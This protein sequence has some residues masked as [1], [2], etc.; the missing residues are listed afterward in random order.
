MLTQMVNLIAHR[1]PDGINTWHEGS[2]GL[3][4]CMLWTTPE[5]VH[6][7]LPLVNSTGEK[8]ITADARIDNRDDLLNTFAINI[9]DATEISDSEII[10]MSYERWGTTCV[11][12]LLGDFAFAIW[13]KRHQQMFCAR[14]HMGIKSFYY[15]LSAEMF[16]FAT[17]IKVLLGM[18]Q[19]PKIINE[20]RVADYLSQVYADNTSTLYQQIYRLPPAHF[21]T[22]GL[23]GENLNRYWSL[24]LVDD[25]QLKSDKEYA[26]R[27]YEIFEKAVRCRLRSS[28]RIGFALSGGLDSSSITCSARNLINDNVVQSLNT[29]SAIF[30]TLDKECRSKVD[31]TEY[32]QTI[33][34]MGGFDPHFIHADKISPL[35]DLEKIISFTDEVYFAPNLF[36]F[37]EL[38]NT[39][40]NEGIRV[41]LDGVDGDLTVS[42]GLE[43]LTDLFR[44]GRW[45]KL[46]DEAVEISRKSYISGKPGKII[47]HY[48]ILPQIPDSI[49]NLRRRFQQKEPPVWHLVNPELVQ[50]LH[51]QDRI[52]NIGRSNA[53]HKRTAKEFHKSDLNTSQLMLDLEVIDKIAAAA[54]L[55]VR[56]PFFD[57]RL[58]EFCVSIPPDQKLSQGWT[59]YIFRRAMEGVL[60]RKIQ[61]RLTKADFNMNFKRALLHYEKDMLER[62]IFSDFKMIEPYVNVPALQA[63]YLRLVNR[64][65]SAVNDAFLVY[66]VIT[67]ALW[68]KIV[69]RPGNVNIE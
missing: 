10:L 9:R 15:Y 35:I 22:V 62:I 50:R 38:Y 8:Y 25:L 7:T 39:A 2:V 44:T 54:C 63:T 40:R 29:F 60:P 67:L 59:R 51:Y 68:L 32:I 4:H 46:I 42:H 49:R 31:E 6:E 45:K 53:I 20:V 23:K 64:S 11:D 24:D 69:S 52:Q 17:E 55:D 65:S 27:F 47:W 41:Y 3:G 16:V 21:M 36:M 28:Y 30:P 37:W 1:G 13:D 58:V 12:K 33:L 61:W 57:R 26:G 66:G 43:L 14:D 5:S 34:S 19:I 56:L 18:Q 48:G